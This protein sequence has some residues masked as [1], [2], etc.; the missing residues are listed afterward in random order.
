[1]ISPRHRHHSEFA[2]LSVTTSIFKEIQPIKVCT[3]KFLVNIFGNI[4]PFFVLFA[5]L[6]T[7]RQG[8]PLYLYIIHSLITENEILYNIDY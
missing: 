8:K 1:M 6:D 3:K 2:S 5:D 4:G 7:Y